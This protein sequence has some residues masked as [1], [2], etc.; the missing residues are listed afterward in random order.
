MNELFTLQIEFTKEKLGFRVEEANRKIK[1]V[2]PENAK[3]KS[4]EKVVGTPALNVDASKPEDESEE[5]A[6]VAS[7]IEGET[8][9]AN[10]QETSAGEIE[11]K[12]Q[13]V[14]TE[15]EEDFNKTEQ[16]A[17]DL[18]IIAISDEE[19]RSQGLIEYLT[20]R[21]IN[22]LALEGK[23][24]AEQVEILKTT[25]KPFT[26]TFTG[27]N[28][29]KKPRVPN[30]AYASILKDLVAE[31]DNDVKST[32]YDMVKGSAVEEELKAGEKA[33]AQPIKALISN[34]GRLISLL[35][36]IKEYE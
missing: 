23:G 14:N 11:E 26:L 33:G 32:F 31:G 36:N 27:P 12:D 15:G 10:E 2:V 34:R 20:L 9:K 25:K 22:K 16:R 5:A 6:K 29:L 21:K 24:F 3:V 13:T 28:Y 1:E 30:T 18:L 17:C 19:L 35:Q 8:E 4:E 7:V